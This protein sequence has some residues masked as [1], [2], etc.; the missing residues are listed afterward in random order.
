MVGEKCRAAIYL[1]LGRC[2]LVPLYLSTYRHAAKGLI[3]CNSHSFALAFTHPLYP[4]PYPNPKNKQTYK[5][6]P[7]RAGVATLPTGEETKIA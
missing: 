2:R 1:T 3:S 5:K 4:Y 6:S 7:T